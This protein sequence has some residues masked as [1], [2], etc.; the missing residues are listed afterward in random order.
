MKFFN[1]KIK[2]LLMSYKQIAG[3]NNTGKITIKNRGG[4]HFNFYRI[5]DYK[6][7]LRYPAIVLRQE[8]SKGRTATIAL[9]LY[10]N[11]I[12]SYIL[13]A[14]NLSNGFII[15]NIN[16]LDINFNSIGSSVLLKNVYAG[17]ILYN[18]ELNYGFG[19][20]YCRSGGAFFQIL[21]LIKYKNLY[22]VLIRLKSKK[23]Y[24]INSNCGGVLGICSTLFYNL[25]YPLKKAGQN[26][27]RGRRPHVRG[28]AMNPVDHPHGGNT[29]GGRCSISFSG[30]LSK[31]FKT[32]KRKTVY[33]I[34]SKK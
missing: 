14:A 34:F 12:L 23:R 7:F 2:N 21:N 29:S 18:L 3:R 6:R 31:G 5:L 17:S 9:I 4:G 32:K 20:Q 1:L 11:G 24:L 33:D 22:L 19:A 25:Y 16:L 8:A 13:S 28:V 27:N 26:R 10:K 15:N 30:V